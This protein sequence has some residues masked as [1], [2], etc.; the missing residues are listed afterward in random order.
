[1]AARAFL[2]LHYESA[3]KCRKWLKYIAFLKVIS[4]RKLQGRVMRYDC[5]VMTCN[6]PLHV[7]VWSLMLW[8]IYIQSF[9]GGEDTIPVPPGC[10]VGV[11]TQK[12]SNDDTSQSHPY[13]PQMQ[14]SMFS[15]FSWRNAIVPYNVTLF[16]WLT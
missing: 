14:T 4:Y 3:N 5:D 12:N 16:N 15:A 13:I 1:M 2:R 8:Q 11:T 6:G 9:H 10:D 7:G